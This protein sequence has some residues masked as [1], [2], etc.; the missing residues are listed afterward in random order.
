LSAEVQR[1]IAALYG[2]LPA[3]AGVVHVVAAAREAGRLRVLKIG[4][5]APKSDTDFFILQLA[6][7]RADAVLTTAR[8]LRE[9]PELSLD[10]AGPWA[11]ALAG[12]RKG[13]GKR[14][15][16]ALILTLGGD[17]PQ[18]HPLWR[19]ALERLVLTAPDKAGALRARLGERAEVL[20]SNEPSP[21]AALSLLAARGAQAISVEA[22]PSTAGT[23]Y[24]PSSCIDELWL[25]IAELPLVSEQLGRA[26][27][28]DATLFAGLRLAS[29]RGRTEQSGPWRFQRWVRSGA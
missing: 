23:L 8:I 12:Y 7:A 15:L 19:D 25:S 9:E 13:L 24:A 27:P 21:R 4:P 2:G 18:E 22:G 11:G 5:E 1:E 20:T 17:L 29:E 6:R 16:T 28:E 10:F 14:R 26:L 3:P